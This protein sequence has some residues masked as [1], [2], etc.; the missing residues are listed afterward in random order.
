MAPFGDAV[1][2]RDGDADGP[3]AAAAVW[4]GLAS[5]RL[6]DLDRVG[7]ADSSP[8]SKG[9]LLEV[10][11][12]K[13]SNG[14]WLGDGVFLLV[15]IGVAGRLELVKLPLRVSLPLRSVSE[16]LEEPDP[17]DLPGPEPASVKPLLP[18]LVPSAIAASTDDRRFSPEAGDMT[19]CKS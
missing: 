1:G 2:L 9:S 16:L 12:V 11:V 14:S 4:N 15:D 13:L 6:C 5:C 19:E 10:E 7:G 17:L 8:L 18:R 3:P